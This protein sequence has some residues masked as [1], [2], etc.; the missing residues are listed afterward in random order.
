MILSFLLSSDVI[1]LISIL[2]EIN[3][4][5]SLKKHYF[6]CLCFLKAKC[7]LHP[8]TGPP[9]YSPSNKTNTLCVHNYVCQFQGLIKCT[10]TRTASLA[11]WREDDCENVVCITSSEAKDEFALSWIRH[12]TGITMFCQLLLMIMMSAMKC[13]FPENRSDPN[14]TTIASNNTRTY[15][16][17]HTVL[18]N[19]IKTW[20]NLCKTLIVC[21]CVWCRNKIAYRMEMIVER[22]RVVGNAASQMIMIVLVAARARVH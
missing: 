10:D 1:K 17:L 11:H 13:E 21:M 14:T 5:L 8:I 18:A 4:G 7:N 2:N 15:M 9:C 3:S 19:Q 22:R 12:S 16:M 6:N 20:I